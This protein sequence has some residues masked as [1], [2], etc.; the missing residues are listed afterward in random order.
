MEGNGIHRPRVHKKHS[1]RL[2]MDDG[3]PGR[4]VQPGM[5]AS[6]LL[7]EQSVTEQPPLLEQVVDNIPGEIQLFMDRRFHR[8]SRHASIVLPGANGT[9]DKSGRV[10][11]G[12]LLQREGMGTMEAW[13]QKASGPA[14]H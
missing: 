11:S 14:S 13:E 4:A 12:W 5:D 10:L 6:E 3:V 9:A 1:Y 2:R 8:R 7:N